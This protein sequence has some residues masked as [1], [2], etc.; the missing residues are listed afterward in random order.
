MAQPQDFGHC[1]NFNEI[2]HEEIRVINRR[3]QSSACDAVQLVDDGRD[4][5]TGTRIIFP[6]LSDDVI[7]LSLSGGGV[8]SAAFCLGALQALHEAKV[9]RRVD[10]LSTVSGGGYIGCS[11]SAALETAGQDA[12]SNGGAIDDD[13]LFPFA[14]ND[15][16]DET[17]STQHIRD[18]SNYLFPS[19]AGDFIQ[20]AAICL[21]GLIANAV[22]ILP[23]LLIAAALTIYSYTQV[24]MPIGAISFP[25]CHHLLSRRGPDCRH[26]RLGLP[27]LLELIP[28]HNRCPEHP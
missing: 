19:G 13:R 8:R 27:A 23:F 16:E 26:A 21:R 20:N 12:Q 1:F 11:L 18:H 24:L 14:V 3:R 17:P 4:D 15:V 10:Y 2:F 5:S 9:L 25:I 6:R 22:V 7:G 28:T